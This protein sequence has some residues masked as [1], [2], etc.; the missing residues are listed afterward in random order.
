MQKMVFRIRGMCCAQEIGLLKDRVGPLVG[1]ELNLQFDLLAGKM[2]VVILGTT[3]TEE[4]IRQ[5]VSSAGMEAVPWDDA[6]PAGTCP[7]AGTFWQR[8]G[9]LVLCALSGLAMV[10]GIAIQTFFAGSLLDALAEGSPE[11]VGLHPLALASYGG[12]VLLG[13]W[14]IAPRALAAARALRPDMNLLMAVAVL[15]AMGIG[16]WLEAASVTFLFSLAL[17]L[18]SWSIGR[19]RNAIKALIDISPLTARFLCPTDGDIE[20][21][22][23]ERVPVG[24]TV[25]VRP[26]E[27]L[28]LDGVV[29]RGST[30]IDQSSITGEPLPV[31]KG[32]GDEVYAGTINLEGSMEFRSTRP[33]SDTT[34]ARI[35]QMVEAAQSR[36]APTEQFVE[37]FARVYTPLMLGVA[38]LIA[39]APPLILGGNWASWLYQA[40]VVLVI[41]CPCSLVI[42]TPVSIVAGLTTAARNG[43]LIKGGAYLEAPARLRAI[44]FD[45]TGTLTHGR[46]VVQQIVPLD[47]HTEEELLARA[48]ALETHSTHP[49]AG[50]IL[51]LA[52]ERGLSY[53]PAEHLTVLPGQGAQ[54]VIDS[55]T[56]WIGSHRLLEE[57]GHETPEAHRIAEELENAGHS[58]VMMWTEDHVCGIMSLTDEI[59]FEAPAVVESLRSL[60]IERLILL[61][62]DGERTGEA[63]A[64]A[65]G[66]DRYQAELLPQDKVEVVVHLNE[67]YGRVAMVGDGINDAPALAAS[68]LG[69]AMGAIGADA[70]IET[71]DV[72]LMSDDLTRLPWLIAHS[73]RTLAVIQQ[74]IFFSLAVKILFLG[75]AA[76]GIATLWSAIAADMGASLLVI[77]NGLRLLG[78][79]PGRVGDGRPEGHPQQ[80]SGPKLSS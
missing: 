44:A 9:P 56:Y 70:A 65:T 52:D 37:R 8:R 29:T 2:T 43:V 57:W 63:V 64:A 41:A 67:K 68:N 23:V 60:G 32:V 12:A 16:E 26:G 73:R 49:V 15:G 69:I 24:A 31:A 18:E 48:A 33:A 50:A 59:R 58:V 14:R 77:F 40:L 3:V 4:A 62:G 11:E 42:S 10:A 7:V 17:L 71:A 38:C 35:I 72:A 74:N 55:R 54:G 21:A 47:D 27:K 6:C 45:K 61:T 20:E 79:G 80:M 36:R 39:V 25:L 76:G 22:P 46:P 34:L 53:T 28:P 75:M 1:G 66:V 51:R 13:G 5:A 30:S 78:S 19:A